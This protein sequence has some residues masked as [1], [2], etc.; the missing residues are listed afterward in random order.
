MRTT[1]SIVTVV[2]FSLAFVFDVCQ[3]ETTFTYQGRLAS[4]GHPAEGNHDFVFRLFD[5][6]T[7]GTQAGSDL[8]VDAVSVVGGIF[9]VSLDFGDAP[10]NSSPRWLEIDVRQANAGM[11]TTLTPRQRVGASPFAIETLFVAPGAVDT[12]ALQDNAVTQSKLADNSVGTSQIQN[13]TV[14]SSDIR[15]GT[16][17]PVDVTANN[18]LLSKS[19]IYLV[20]GNIANMPGMSNAGATASCADANDVPIAY[21]CIVLTTLNS[22]VLRNTSQQFWDSDAEAASVTCSYR[23]NAQSLGADVQAEIACMTVD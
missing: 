20:G 9:T 2:V 19:G 1:Q 18:T 4:A 22:V 17:Q 15:D 13:N 16:I 8:A 12:A 5:M 3:A 10:F 23:N 14:T 11:Y 7:G 21:F 6:E